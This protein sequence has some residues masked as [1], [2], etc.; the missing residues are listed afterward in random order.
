M[1]DDDDDDDDGK[2]KAAFFVGRS[3]NATGGTQFKK[4]GVQWW[5]AAPVLIL[6][7]VVFGWGQS[8]N[9]SNA[10]PTAL[11][12]LKHESEQRT[13]QTRCPWDTI[14]SCHCTWVKVFCDSEGPKPWSNTGMGA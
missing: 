7:G 3:D 10:D 1:D 8:Q 2:P 14:S 12:F 4:P 9:A 5:S 13:I 11:T 6:G